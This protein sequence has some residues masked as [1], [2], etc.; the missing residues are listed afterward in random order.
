MIFAIVRLTVSE[1]ILQQTS[2][3]GGW[4]ISLNDFASTGVVRQQ[5]I[6]SR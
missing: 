3:I 5:L 2:N 4:H 1:P 6:R